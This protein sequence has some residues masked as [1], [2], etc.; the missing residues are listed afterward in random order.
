MEAVE[1]GVSP[2]KAGSFALS[3]CIGFEYESLFAEKQIDVAKRAV[4]ME[5]KGGCFLSARSVRR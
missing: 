4:E 5:H 2:T 3:F 1:Y